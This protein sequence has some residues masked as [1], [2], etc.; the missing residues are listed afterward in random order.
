MLPASSGIICG[1]SIAV[2]D[3]AAHA[4][5]NHLD[6][7][8]AADQTQTAAQPKQGSTRV[9]NV[10]GGTTIRFG[11]NS[12]DFEKWWKQQDHQALLADAGGWRGAVA[13]E[14]FLILIPTACLVFAV[15][16]FWAVC[17]IQLRRPW[18][19][20][21]AAAIILLACIFA[22]IPAVEWHMLAAGWSRMAARQQLGLPT[23]VLCM[24]FCTVWLGL[25]L[26]LGRPLTRIAVR[27]L[28][29]PRLRS[30]LALLWT[31]EGLAPPATRP[32]TP[33]P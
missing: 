32:S 7:L 21:C 33:S 22:I 10:P 17:L 6:D 2:T 3:E 9:I 12:G 31:A 23:L 29:P 14:A 5:A 19:V 8:Q 28:L 1:M 20:V 15:G 30:S 13:G 4:Y 18:L 25:G 11:P 24:G 27:G 16:W 26:W